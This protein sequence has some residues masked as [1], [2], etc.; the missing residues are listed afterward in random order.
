MSDAS[1]A[2]AP[3]ERLPSGIAGLDVILQGGLLRGGFYI[4]AGEPGT[5]KTILANQISFHLA[6][7]YG[8]VLYVTLLAENH[9][10]MF[11]HLRPL[12]FFEPGLV[13]EGILYFSGYGALTNEGL[14]GL[15]QFL[16]RAIRQHRATL[17]VIDALETI[18]DLAETPLALKRLIHELHVYSESTGCTLLA[19]AQPMTIGSA[20]VYAMVD[21]VIELDDRALGLRNVRELVVRKLR[22]SDYLR[23]SHQF[24]IGER[25]VEVYPRT[26]SRYIGPR[27]GAMATQR[28]SIGV[29]R[30]DEMIDGGLRAGS[31]TMLLG[32]P[33]SGK[34]VLG[35][36]FLAAGA[37]RGEPGLYFGG[38]EAPEQVIEK[39]DRLGLD[40]S[41]LVAQGLIEISPQQELETIVDREAERLLQLVDQQG[42]RRL[43]ID[44][45]ERFDPGGYPE[46]L[47]LFF[48]ALLGELGA[49]GVTALLSVQM[50][51]LFGPAIE[52]PVHELSSVV[53]NI[54]LLRAVEL[55]AQLYRLLSVLK[56]RDSSYDST[57]RE[58][59][60]TSAGLE[61]AATFESA[62][63]ILTG[64]ARPVQSGGGPPP[65]RALRRQ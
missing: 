58:F 25:G 1:L 48:S 31:S 28:M 17:L 10:R 41:S 14:S 54:M 6:G 27:R 38:V 43:V 21:G 8:R 63:A 33:G 61:V 50:R 36:H 47:G 2:S 64:L 39:G 40:L 30:L 24:A 18:V 5:G 20:P 57:L 62:E 7:E 34:T 51:Q 59:R 15:A 55:H 22:G 56:A 16:R 60:I 65:R 45:I 42:A 12:A 23:G 19:L 29:S 49:R 35:L 46:R 11:A 26:E 3:L 37:R 44:G 52:V 53:D 9:S 32:T 13:G 4:V